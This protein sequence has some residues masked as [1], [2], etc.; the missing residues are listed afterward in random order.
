[1]SCEVI[2]F[3]LAVKKSYPKKPYKYHRAISPTLKFNH[4]KKNNR[5]RN[6]KN[7]INNF[8]PSKILTFSS[9]IFQKKRK[10]K[11]TIHGLVGKLRTFFSDAS[12]EEKPIKDKP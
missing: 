8:F 4:R 5:R 7:K 6:S 9:K 1:M 2:D 3:L 11:K 10:M 12:D